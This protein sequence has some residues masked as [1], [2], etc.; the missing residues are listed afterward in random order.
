MSRLIVRDWC[1]LFR[2]IVWIATRRDDAFGSK[3]RENAVETFP[4]LPGNPSN[5]AREERERESGKEKDRESISKIKNNCHG[6]RGNRTNSAVPGEGGGPDDDC[7][8]VSGA[9]AFPRVQCVSPP[10]RN[11]RALRISARR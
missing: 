7:L 8:L 1:F 6:G 11:P 3:E 5:A 10:P 2:L 9:F 4:R